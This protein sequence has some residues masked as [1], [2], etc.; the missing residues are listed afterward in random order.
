M[1]YIEIRDHLEVYFMNEE[2]INGKRFN[3]QTLDPAGAYRFGVKTL[4]ICVPPQTLYIA[5]N[6]LPMKRV[7]LYNYL[8]LF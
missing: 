1:R 5:E 6:T 2:H 7:F 4:H 3:P 8:F